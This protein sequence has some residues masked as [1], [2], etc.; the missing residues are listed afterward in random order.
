M[1]AKMIN[2]V[3]ERVALMVK[4]VNVQNIM[5]QFSNKEEAHNWLIKAAIATLF[6]NN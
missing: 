1:K 2:T 3:N 5:M 4:D 6:G